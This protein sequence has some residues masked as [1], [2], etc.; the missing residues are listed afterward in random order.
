[1]SKAPHVIVLGTGGAGLTA[2]ISAHEAGARVS[3]FIGADPAQIDAAARAGAPCVELHTGA[4]A[5]AWWAQDDAAVQAELSRLQRG[6]AHARGLGLRTHAGHGLALSETGPAMPW[7]MD[8]GTHRA[9]IMINP[10]RN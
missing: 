3:L 2:A 1:M 5:N 9:H 8:P 10:P 7:I 4:L 6:I